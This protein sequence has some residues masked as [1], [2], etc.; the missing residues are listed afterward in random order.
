MR[1]APFFVWS[2]TATANAAAMPVDT[3]GQLKT[4]F[5]NC[6]L[7]LDEISIGPSGWAN[8]FGASEFDALSA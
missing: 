1:L 3:E 4:E 6:L 2:E 5:D 8:L 7:T